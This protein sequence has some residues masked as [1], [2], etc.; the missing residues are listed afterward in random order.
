MFLF[1]QLQRWNEKQ[2]RERN[3]NAT[4][5]SDHRFTR[6][7]CI[8]SIPSLFT[9]FTNTGYVNEHN[10]HY[11]SRENSRWIRI[12]LVAF[13]YQW[14][15]NVCRDIIDNVI[16]GPLFDVYSTSTIQCSFLENVS[17]QTFRKCIFY[18]SIKNIMSSK[19]GAPLYF[20][21][22]ER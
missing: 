9:T 15:L 19:Y 16:I 11:R 13:Q 10:L 7:L 8:R 1:S 4:I 18:L 2:F 5:G 22:N 6:R 20:T 3:L 14:S 21:S 17:P 12:G